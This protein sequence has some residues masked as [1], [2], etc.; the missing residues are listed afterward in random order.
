M[1]ELQ[2]EGGGTFTMEMFRTATERA[3]IAGPKAE[4]LLLSLRNQGEVI[5]PRANQYQLVRF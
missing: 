3:G 4:A 1:R 2:E 5:E